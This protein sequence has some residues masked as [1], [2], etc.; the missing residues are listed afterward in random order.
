[1]CNSKSNP[2]TLPT[3]AQVKKTWI[4]T[5]AHTQM[6]MKK[7]H[8]LHLGV[9]RTPSRYPLSEEGHPCW[10]CQCLP[11]SDSAGTPLVEDSPVSQTQLSALWNI[12]V[13]CRN[14]AFVKDQERCNSEVIGALHQPEFCWD[15]SQSLKLYES[16]KKTIDNLH[17]G[18]LGYD[19]I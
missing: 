11:G 13:A 9:G 7:P 16:H 5:F 17:Y 6:S 3:A 4:Y 19:K 1:M 18:L 14:L 2:N 15:T 8:L 12:S 10:C